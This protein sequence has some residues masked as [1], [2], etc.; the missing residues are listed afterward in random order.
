MLRPMTSWRAH[1]LGLGLVMLSACE[2]GAPPSSGSA[3][4][5]A[6]PPPSASAASRLEDGVLLR[7]RRIAT[8]C[9]WDDDKGFDVCA[10][11]D[12]LTAEKT[13][14]A[15]RYAAA[16]KLLADPEPTAR[17]VGLALISAASDPVTKMPLEVQLALV[18]AAK[19]EVVPALDLR[20]AIAVAQIEKKADELREPL[21]ALVRTGPTDVRA[22]ALMSIMR[23]AEDPPWVLAL[24]TAALK[25]EDPRI[26]KAALSGFNAGRFQGHRS[27]TCNLLREMLADPDVEVRSAARRSIMGNLDMM[28][29]DPKRGLIGGRVWPNARQC[30]EPE[31]DAA[32]D[33]EAKDE[34]EKHTSPEARALFHTGA[35]LR[36]PFHGDKLSE[37]SKARRDLSVRE[38]TAIAKD[39]KAPQLARLHAI[40][41]LRLK[42]AGD[43]DKLLGALAK[44][45]DEVV[46]KAASAPAD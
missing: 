26:R 41:G 24:V 3:S 42:V 32:Y 10:A 46:A 44:D 12:T 17:R 2:S 22:V 7:A 30:D 11:L 21:E 14:P 45:H 4:G 43:N 39:T 13:E 40:R 9:K 35:L 20:L 18:E 6:T 34:R 29:D 28:I 19:K 27:E 15:V 5:E 36:G 1:W 25:D 23:G 37:K 33:S 8:E 16:E 31:V 38:L